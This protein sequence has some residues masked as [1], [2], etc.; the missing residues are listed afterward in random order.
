MR[1]NRG[2]L[3]QA[4]L[5]T[6]NRVSFQQANTWVEVLGQFALDEQGPLGKVVTPTSSNKQEKGIVKNEA[7]ITE[8]LRVYIDEFKDVGE[9]KMFKG[10]WNKRTGE[11]EGVGIQFWPDGSKYEG[12]W[13][14]GQAAGRGRMTHANGDV[15]EG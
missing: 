6:P 4:S 3:L 9:G 12:Q 11:R 8:E 13:H 7:M 15:Y 2:D 5:V 1:N 10:Q 14:K